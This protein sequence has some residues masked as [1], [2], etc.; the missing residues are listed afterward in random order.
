MA[1]ARNIKPGLFENEDLTEQSF[2]VRLLFIGLWTL[3][4]REGRLEDRPRQIKRKLFPCDDDDVD[5]ALT[6]LAKLGFIQRYVSG[7]FNVIQIVNFLKHQTPHGTEK[8]SVLPDTQ[9]NFAIH[10]RDSKGYVIGK[11]R[12]NNVISEE[13]ND[14][15]QDKTKS[16]LGCKRPDSPNPDSLIQNNLS[17][18]AAA[19]TTAA[20]GEKTPEVLLPAFAELL[21]NLE[22]ARG[23]TFRLEG[24]EQVFADW[25]AKGVTE[26]HV[27]EAHAIAVQRRVKAGN[28][29]AVNVGLLDVILA[30][31]TRSSTSTVVA[32]PP[33]D[34]KEARRRELQQRHAGE[35]FDGP[36][37]ERFEV[38]SN[39]AVLMSSGTGFEGALNPSQARAFWDDVDAGIVTPRAA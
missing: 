29:S 26:A 5:A 17:E 19:A 32:L 11:K 8:D 15:P 38:M 7:E 14:T 25:Q 35:V 27:R 2:F 10:E 16:Q 31:L 20:G 28:T 12:K 4:D 21:Q 36:M 37:N 34:P 13:N 39:G 23:C 33:V 30:D 9:G 18:Q 6:V 3:A 1:R 24:T 22:T